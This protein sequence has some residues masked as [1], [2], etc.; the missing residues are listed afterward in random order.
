MN[1]RKK[2]ITFAL[3]ILVI[4]IS[5][6]VIAGWVTGNSFLKSIIPGQV[7]MKFNTAFCFVLMGISL[8]IIDNKKARS[9]LVICSW[10][11]MITGTLT[12]FEHLFNWNAGIDELL[13][14]TGERIQNDAPPG[15]PSILASL[16][17]VLMG[18]VFLNKK[19]NGH[20]I[21]WVFLWFVFLS[22]L[23]SLLGY[24]FGLPYFYSVP[25]LSQMALHTTILFILLSFGVYLTGRAEHLLISFRKKVIAG[26]ILIMLVM[27]TVLV[28]YNRNDQYFNSTSRWLQHTNEVLHRS[29]EAIYQVT[30]IE[31]GIRSYLLTG[32]EKF[33]DS[34]DN[35]KRLAL[36][37]IE[38]LRVQTK[39]NP[40]Q[41]ERVQKMKLLI[42]ER[43]RQFDRSISARGQNGYSVRKAFQ[44]VTEGTATMD[45]IRSLISQIQ[46]NEYTLLD[47][48]KVDNRYSINSVRRI[49]F[50]FGFVMFLI[51]FVLLSVIVRN[52]NAR[53][54]A[55]NEAV[56][57]ND[58]LEKRVTQRTEE[59]LKAE[60]KFHYT[61]DNMMEGAQIIDFNWKYIYVND[62]LLKYSHFTREELI[63]QTV[64]ERY[65]GIEQAPIFKVFERCMYDRESI[66]LENEFLFPD[67]S[68]GW[69]ELS[70]QPIPDGI[71]ILSVDITERKRSEYAVMK[72][73]EDIA[74]REKR[75][76][77]IIE[78][79]NDLVS[80]LDK[81][82]KPVYR[83]PSAE[84]ITGWTFDEMQ[85]R[86]GMAE[87]IHPEDVQHF[88]AA[89]QQSIDTPE[90]PIRVTFRNKHKKGHYIWMEGS[91]TNMLND[92]SLAAIVINLQDISLRKHS[93]E[94][95][96]LS[97]RT[98]RLIASSIP[99]S[100]ICLFDRDLRYTLVEGDM[101]EKL[102]YHKEQLLG[103]TLEE[104]LPAER[105]K[106]VRPYFDR[107]LSGETFAMDENRPGYDTISRYVALKD[108]NGYVYAAM[109]V[110]FDISELKNAQRSLAE[111]NRQLE[112]RIM[113]RTEQLATANK[114]L[115]SFSY[116]VSHDLRAPLRGI[117][118]WSLALIED[119]GQQLDEKAHQYLA[120]VRNETQRMGELI[121]DMLKLSKVSRTEIKLMDVNISDLANEVVARLEEENPQRDFVFTVQPGLHI[122]GD[123]NLLEIMLTNLFANA[124]KFTAKISP[125]K[126]EFGTIQVEGRQVFFIKD[127]GVGFDM[128]NAKKLFGAF[129][130][131]H[132][133]SEFPGTG[134]GLATVQRIINL[135][136]GQVWAEAAINKGATFYFT[137]S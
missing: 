41:S 16:N 114:E 82:I 26:F 136:H 29:E 131:M 44:L 130:R 127:N 2:D 121:D 58:T 60:S 4:L 93:E 8:A 111:L 109:V 83:S 36:L 46:Q 32:S 75:F 61:L 23:F 125:S 9:F 72:L 10:L 137:I 64:M 87:Q 50:F 21:S 91:F 110:V 108:Q 33:L 132:R 134:I 116:S 95:L 30:T 49:I 27:V 24:I 70:Y 122:T 22:A 80:L 48:R 11:V 69:F 42:I 119:Y 102:G 62:A 56:Q 85:N 37:N 115:E 112:Y 67:G 31:S 84:R 63:G 13:W 129:Q 135:H 1:N 117:D 66:H 97:E 118:G 81:D 98:Y 54:K 20:F 103:K 76:R 100:V 51:L 45:S 65:P 78:S 39:D 43:F 59:L 123:A 88:A 107:V 3:G 7:S 28:I 14:K 106:V 38:V 104:A 25:G 105:F 86:G 90:L 96:L 101:L 6:L 126:I 17:F 73:N 71:F 55:E 92:K 34:M 113:E 120:R 40:V 18:I 128:E 124:C 77:T 89:W 15:R 94:Q 47:K 19:R 12:L 99:G 35:K 133:Q 79:S 53:I 5:S 52:I 74:Q 57:L 68:T